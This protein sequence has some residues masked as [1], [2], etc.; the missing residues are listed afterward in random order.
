MVPFTSKI[1]TMGLI[2]FCPIAIGHKAHVQNQINEI[3]SLVLIKMQ[4]SGKRF[5]ILT[6]F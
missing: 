3:D 2:K 6:H 5:L 1:N 4:V